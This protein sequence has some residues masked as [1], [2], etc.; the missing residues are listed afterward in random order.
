PHIHTTHPH[1]MTPLPHFTETPTPST[2]FIHSF[3][4]HPLNIS[5]QTRFKITNSVQ[6]NIVSRANGD[7]IGVDAIEC[8]EVVRAPTGVSTWLDVGLQGTHVDIPYEEPLF[9]QKVRQAQLKKHNFTYITTLPNNNVKCRPLKKGICEL[10]DPTWVRGD[11][12]ANIQL[13]RKEEFAKSDAVEHTYY[14]LDFTS[15][16]FCFVLELKLM[17]LGLFNNISVGH[18]AMANKVSSMFVGM[19]DECLECKNAIYQAEKFL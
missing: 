10:A 16:L 19:K 17:N 14:K 1:H 5:Y 2:F 13:L 11:T 18:K 6:P 15:D 9:A 3:Y 12:D 4:F 8:G 7:P